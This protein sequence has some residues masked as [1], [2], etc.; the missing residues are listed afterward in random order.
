MYADK[1]LDRESKERIEKW[2]LDAKADSERLKEDGANLRK[3]A[4]IDSIQEKNNNV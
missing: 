4:E 1:Q 2:K 3:A